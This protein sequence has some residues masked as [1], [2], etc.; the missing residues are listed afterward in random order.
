MQFNIFNNNG[1]KTVL[2]QKRVFSR[3][4]K[5][6]EEMVKKHFENGCRNIGDD[7][8]IIKQSTKLDKLIVDEMLL[9]EMKKKI[10]E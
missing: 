6:L 8:R 9:C 5:K 3:E 4:Q 2:K 1:E 7:K 10:I